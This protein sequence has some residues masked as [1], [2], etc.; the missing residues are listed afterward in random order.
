MGREGFF[1]EVVRFYDQFLKGTTP[2]VQDPRIA[3]QTNDGKWRA[4]ESWPPA[5][6]TGYTSALRT[7]S[8]S[9]DGSGSATGTS[10]TEGVWTIS[11]RLPHAAHLAGSGKAVVD[12]AT[13]GPTPTSWSTCMTSTSSASAR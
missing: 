12:V 5:D 7:G 3:V 2:A 11:P 6:A 1:D 9:D 13:T 8:Y 10:D 4:E